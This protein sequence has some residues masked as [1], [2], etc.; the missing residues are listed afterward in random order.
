MKRK[1]LFGML[2]FL[3]FLPFVAFAAE[4]APVIVSFGDRSIL[5]SQSGDLLTAPDRF[6]Y[7]EKISPD[8]APEALYA[9]YLQDPA[10]GFRCLLLN[11]RGAEV[12]QETFEFLYPN[13]EKS[14][15]AVRDSKFGVVS[16]SLDPIIAPTYTQLVPN[17][18]GGY[19]ALNTDPYDERPD[20]VYYILPNG[21]E[22]ATGVRVSFGLGAF[23]DGLMP[24]VA[25]DS[26][27]MGYLNPQGD[28]AIPP[29]FEYAGDFIGRRAEA[30][31]DSGAGLIDQNGNW[32]L[33]PK[34]VTV[35]LAGKS[36]DLILAQV[37]STEIFLLDPEHYTVKA[38]YRG[39]DIYFSA[40]SDSDTAT[41]FL[42]D[43]TQVISK[44]GRV[45]LECQADAGF[46]AYSSLKDCLI[47]RFGV[48]GDPCV[49]LYDQTGKSVSGPF[50]DIV[51]LG[52]Q[53]ERA[54][55]ACSTFETTE[56]K[57]ESL[58]WRS[59]SEVTGTRKIEII[60]QTGALVS[61]AVLCNAVTLDPTSGILIYD[62]SQ[63]MRLCTVNGAQIAEIPK[64]SGNSSEASSKLF[65]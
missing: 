7:I 63:A 31:L 33:T 43:C 48:W 26:G 10:E 60:D 37:G 15:L 64:K 44:D 16:L 52:L 18:E 39:Q 58:N 11:A 40:Y 6:V 51:P 45:I 14:F 29:Q 62:E 1:P 3:C 46:D 55:F 61:P 5:V 47:T 13:D 38:R 32:L 34:Y 4:D 57:D 59:L 36:G 8:N 28:W 9:A 21:E 19:L 54:L 27:R 12:S 30:C 42:D 41:L 50:Q 23:R 22:R 25:S 53:G 24:A 20:G 35:T 65:G 17:G 56:E 49:Y 2:L